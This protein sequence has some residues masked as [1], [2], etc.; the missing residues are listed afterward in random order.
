MSK[1]KIFNLL[2][3]IIAI[4][5]GVI[6]SLTTIINGNLYGTL[7]RLSI[8][9]VM[10]L[11]LIFKK[12]L[13]Q[14]IPL[15]LETVYLIFVFCAHYLGS[16]LNLYNTIDNY[17]KIMHLLSGIISAVLA[18]MILIKYKK[19]DRHHLW[20]NILFMIAFTMMIA[21]F[22][23]FY[24]FKFDILFSKDAQKVAL[25]GVNDT[26]YDMAS[27]LMGGVVLSTIYAYIMIPNKL[28]VFKKI[29]ASVKNKV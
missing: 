22:W 4:T 6:S 28:L 7:I 25:T 20:F 12:G 1:T 26:M 23:E 17:D 21:I 9:P 3:I 14:K 2:L 5:G 29:I 19:Y 24:E 15:S 10:L 18:L 16:I 11:P 8:I 27:A 13:K